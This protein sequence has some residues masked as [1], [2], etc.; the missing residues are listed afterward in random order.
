MNYTDDVFEAL[1]LQDAIQTRY[2]GGTVLH[3]F[4]GERVE[5]PDTIKGLIRK[6]CESYHLPYFTFT[7]T[8]SVCPSHGY[9]AGEHYTC[10]ECGAE[11]EV[12]S[13]VVGYLRPIKQWNKGKR[14]EFRTRKT[15]VVE[16]VKPLEL[17]V[18]RGTALDSSTKTRKAV[19]VKGNYGAVEYKQLDLI[20]FSDDVDENE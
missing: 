20:S 5:D 19:G 3:I 10:P 7:P 14:E 12:Y 2:T 13:R 11:T 15:F 4:A 17:G 1:D 8:F 9:V 6:I 16:P 18:I